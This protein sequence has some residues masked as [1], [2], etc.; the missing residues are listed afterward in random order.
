M[1]KGKKTGGR[2]FVPG[3]VTNPNGRPKIPPEVKTL[4]KLTTESLAEIGDLILQGDKPRLHEIANSLTEPAIRV[5]YAKATI[6]AM[7]K[8]DLST[9]ELIL[10]RVVGKVKDKVDLGSQEGGIVLKVVDYTTNKDEK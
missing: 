10:N 1:A 2:N 4:R 5:A 3:V 7:V 8:G 6:N 9:L